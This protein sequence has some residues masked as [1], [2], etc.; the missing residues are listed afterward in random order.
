MKNTDTK[1]TQE[2]KKSCC[3]GPH[4][5]MWAAL[6]IAVVV[7][8]IVGAF[9][10]GTRYAHTG[11]YGKSDMY[12]RPGMMMGDHDKDGGR[13]IRTGD[14]NRQNQLV[15]K[16]ITH[17]PMNMSMS[18]MS[19][20]LAGKTG[21]DLNKTFLEMMIPHHEAAVEMA[22]VLAGSDKPELVKLGAD[23]ITAQT[24]EIEKMQQWMID[25]G[26]TSTG[27]LVPTTTA[28]GDTTESI[29]M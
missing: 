9:V 17:D 10:L 11:L 15:Q 29:P 14:G 5:W 26:Y 24:A 3:T 8:L 27:E 4:F 19:Q 12:G 23:I 18:D 28:S 22:K 2:S 21:D 7:A 16:E 1:S 6:R 25:W 13:G 20:M